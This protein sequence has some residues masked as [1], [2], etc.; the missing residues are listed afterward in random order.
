MP[1]FY[2]LI[3]PICFCFFLSIVL[4]TLVNYK[5]VVLVDQPQSLHL[6]SPFIIQSNFEAYFHY[7]FACV[8]FYRLHL[9]PLHSIPIWAS[10]FPKFCLEELSL[11]SIIEF[12]LYAA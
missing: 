4:P 1:L 10:L 3:H 7:N 11:V 5:F 2:E 6:S 12:Q 9:I 8:Y